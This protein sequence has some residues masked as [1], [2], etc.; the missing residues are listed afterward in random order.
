[1]SG[2]FAISSSSVPNSFYPEDMGAVC[3]TVA[4]ANLPFDDT[5]GGSDATAEANPPYEP[6]INPVL[7]GLAEVL[8]DAAELRRSPGLFL[9]TEL[10]SEDFLFAVPETLDDFS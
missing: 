6:L 9:S 7:P 1:M 2:L 10:V 3:L 4:G 8:L 5:F